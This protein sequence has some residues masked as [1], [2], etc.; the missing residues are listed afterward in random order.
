MLRLPGGELAIVDRTKLTE[1]CL[2]PRHP[3][4]KHKAR[5]FASVLGIT[6]R[7]EDLLRSALLQAARTANAT[8]MASDRFG[9]P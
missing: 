1:Y 7:E 3:R 5:V 6:I 8:I 9:D 4:G 2:D